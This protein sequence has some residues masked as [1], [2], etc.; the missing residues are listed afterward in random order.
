MSR[1]MELLVFRFGISSFIICRFIVSL[2]FHDASGF[3]IYVS[4]FHPCILLY[5]FV[6]F[7]GCKLSGANLDAAK[8]HWLWH[9]HRSAPG[10]RKRE[11][12]DP[13][14]SIE[15][16]NFQCA[17]EAAVYADIEAAFKSLGCIGWPETLLRSKCIA[18]FVTCLQIS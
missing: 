15:F 1:S 4:S 11:S 6:V 14:R 3:F 2:M 10:A 8:V 12:F 18:N 7:V 5:F 13:S 16:L 9:E 17:K